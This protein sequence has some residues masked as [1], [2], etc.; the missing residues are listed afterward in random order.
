MNEKYIGQFTKWRPNMLVLNFSDMSNLY[1]LDLKKRGILAASVV[2]VSQEILENM[3][4]Y[5]G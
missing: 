4:G 5:Q 1:K 3:L 2:D